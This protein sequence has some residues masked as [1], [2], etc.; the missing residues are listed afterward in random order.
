VE[1]A[2]YKLKP[3]PAQPE[4]TPWHFSDECRHAFGTLK[5]AFTTAPVLT[6]WIP[7][8]PLIIETDASDYALAV[9]LSL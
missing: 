6:H 4:H 8:T 5:K 2:A 9:I 1:G 3:S 7:D